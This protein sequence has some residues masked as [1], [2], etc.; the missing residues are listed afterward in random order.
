MA[1]EVAIPHSTPIISIPSELQ[2]QITMNLSPLDRIALKLT[3]RHFYNTL[4]P[5]T[6]DELFYAQS[7]FCVNRTMKKSRR[8]YG[9]LGAYRACTTCMRLRPCHKFRNG[10]SD[11]VMHFIS[12]GYEEI[13]WLVRRGHALCQ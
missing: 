11:E 8:Q 1:M 5:L 13:K 7:V 2:L 6:L 4:E 10:W 12:N 9:V 3:N